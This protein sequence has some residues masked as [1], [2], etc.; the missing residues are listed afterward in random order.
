[1]IS[2]RP[3]V[4]VLLAA[5]V[6]VVL[7][8][9]VAAWLSP[10]SL[11]EMKSLTHL[12][13]SHFPQIR[14]EPREKLA[15]LLAALFGTLGA[16]I[17]ARLSTRPLALPLVGLGAIG[18]IW[19]LN[20]T[21]A[22][23][24]SEEMAAPQLTITLVAFFGLAALVLRRPNETVSAQ[25]S[26]AGQAAAGTR[27]WL[28]HGL[29]ALILLVLLLPSSFEAVAAKVGY[30]PHVV[31]F[32][33][34][35]ALYRFGTNLVPGVDYYTQYSVGLPYLFSLVL[36]ETAAAT[37]VRYA[38]LMVASMYL[39]YLAAYFGVA[40]L[41]RSR[42]WALL[43]VL[44]GLFLN[45]HT[46]RP[47]FDPSSYVLRH[48]LLVITI[49]LLA[50]WIAG[51]LLVRRGMALAGTLAASLFLNSE[52][53]VLQIVV[54]GIVA[55]FAGRDPVRGGLAAL[56]MASAAVLLFL[57]AC[58]L[59]FG[60]ATLS[61]DFLRYFLEP[62]FIYAGGYGA[63]PMAW[64]WDWGAFYNVVAPGLALGVFGWALMRLKGTSQGSERSRLAGLAAVAG[65]AVM[66]SMKYWNQSLVAI[67]HVNALGFLIVAGWWCR[68]NL[69]W[70]NA[71]ARRPSW[72]PVRQFGLVGLAL[73][74]VSI[75]TFADDARNP[76]LYG[77]HA[78]LAYPS[79]LA[80]LIGLGDSGCRDMQCAGTSP[81]PEDIRLI[82]KYVKPGERAALVDWNDW[83]A[84]LEAQRAPKFVFMPSAGTFT[85][86]Q[87]EQSLA[88][89]DL[90]FI[91]FGPK[92]VGG[93]DEVLILNEEL[94]ERLEPL[95]RDEFFRLER[96]SRYVV[97]SRSYPYASREQFE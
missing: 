13:P 43:I 6:G 68:E 24:L 19:G 52:T 74:A 57:F 40:Y 36:P 12:L 3:G 66:L 15:F 16:M 46:A 51:D 47:F 44:T 72:L 76:S 37:M 31:S 95:L 35:P 73:F 20:A 55:L 65:M 61:L 60:P 56:A 49:P 45:F 54:V 93:Q 4:S 39:Y 77:I 9:A 50:W 79:A 8:A 53:G 83:L 41:L 18:L 90:I 29:A 23:A 75:A 89:L 62:F 10:I 81:A 97:F 21:F 38:A 25:A 1:M 84:L 88:G 63:V 34:G 70:L 67:W 59:A 71:H 85:W 33:I 32:V 5:S 11:D 7:A 80:Q 94:K 78:Y 58:A 28:S 82:Q 92:A 96:G 2:G 48:P 17:G 14:P 30:E 27:E 91:A 64:T 87:L 69:E 86:R 26:P 22:F 42:L